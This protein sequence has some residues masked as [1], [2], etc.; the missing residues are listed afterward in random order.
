MGRESP[1]VVLPCL[2]VAFGFVVRDWRGEPKKTIIWW[3][4]AWKHFKKGR[5]DPWGLG[6]FRVRS[7]TT[8][9]LPDQTVKVNLRVVIAGCCLCK[10][11]VSK[12]AVTFCSSKLIDQK[13]A[14]SPFCGHEVSPRLEIDSHDLG[15]LTSW[16][17]GR[18][19]GWSEGWM[20][21]CRR[22]GSL[23]RAPDGESGPWCFC[24]SSHSY[25]YGVFT[26][27]LWASFFFT[28]KDTTFCVS[29]CYSRHYRY[30][31]EYLSTIDITTLAG[32]AG[33]FG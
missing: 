30:F 13:C 25:D 20:L 21:G 16:C 12:L 11:F 1:F 7:T 14:N 18:G 31:T 24:L 6:Y 2:P 15:V 19:P 5:G 23:E 26:F 3:W 29:M 10:G 9:L 17:S 33:K 4:S 8:S 22:C 28:A 27:P 32:K